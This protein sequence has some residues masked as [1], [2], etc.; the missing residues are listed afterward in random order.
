LKLPVVYKKRFIQLKLRSISCGYIFCWV[1]LLLG[2]KCLH[3]IVAR[4]L[5]DYILIRLT[6]CLLYHASCTVPGA[7]GFVPV[8][9][10]LCCFSIR[11]ATMAS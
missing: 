3:P 4:G 1:A 2:V 8:H 6:A 7:A 10:W 11:M 9:V 5:G